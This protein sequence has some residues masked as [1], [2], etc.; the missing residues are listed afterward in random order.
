MEKKEIKEVVFNECLLMN[1]F[2]TGCLHGQKVGG[3]TKYRQLQTGGGVGGQKSLKMCGHPLWMAPSVA[4]L[5]IEYFNF[6]LTSLCR[7]LI[8]KFLAFQFFRQIKVLLFQEFVAD[9]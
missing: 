3:S 6:N 4:F 5:P 2:L 8:F 9:Q 1:I 7:Y